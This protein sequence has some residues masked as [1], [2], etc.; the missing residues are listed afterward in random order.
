MGAPPTDD[1]PLY[2][3]DNNGSGQYF[4]RE[5]RSRWAGK[6]PRPTFVFGLHAPLDGPIPRFNRFGVVEN[7]TG[8]NP[9]RAIQPIGQNFLGNRSSS[10][11]TSSSEESHRFDGGPA[12][13]DELRYRAMVSCNWDRFQDEA[14]WDNGQRMRSDNRRH[15][16]NN[17]DPNRTWGYNL[18][19]TENA[20][21]RT[22]RVQPPLP[23]MREARSGVPD[24]V[25]TLDNPDLALALRGADGHPQSEWA[26]RHAGSTTVEHDDC[27]P[28]DPRYPEIEEEHIAR[29]HDKP[30]A[31][32]NINQ[33]AWR[34]GNT[35]L[36]GRFYRV[37]IQTLEQAFNLVSFL[38]VGQ[39]EAYELFTM[40]EI[41]RAWW[42]TTTGITRP[43]RHE[44]HPNL[45]KT[46]RGL[47]HGTA[48]TP[49]RGITA[50]P[51]S[52]H[53]RTTEQGGSHSYGPRP[54]A[55]PTAPM[56]AMAPT[57][58][59]AFGT[60]A[61]PYLASLL[62][63]TTYWPLSPLPYHYDLGSS[64]TI[65]TDYAQLDLD[66]TLLHFRSP[67]SLLLLASAT[68]GLT[69]SSRSFAG[70][71]SSHWNLWTCHPV[72]VSPLRFI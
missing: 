3:E 63:L 19:A 40:I 45:Y 5:Q 1:T 4:Q 38:D 71:S 21:N 24:P 39:Q 47:I 64:P 9:G 11:T 17:Y 49:S 61:L 12:Q 65:P 42:D 6:L 30:L 27:P 37:Q 32:D 72:L 23:T 67:R 26:I 46:P 55:G 8:D 57:Q 59:F 53:P 33:P 14:Y 62:V 29:V 54:N 28:S 70:H 52:A 50:G 35:I 13:D 66:H 48:R 25:R 69:S 51:L 56:G 22:L 68:P 41:N 10:G 44:R 7:Y 2:I 15:P 31:P 43:P 20:Q 18:A 36:L 60:A 16:Y 58:T 34:E